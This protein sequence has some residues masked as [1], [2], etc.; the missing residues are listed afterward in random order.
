MSEP[1]KAGDWV[2]VIHWHPCGCRLGYVRQVY[3]IYRNN[4]RL[5]YCIPCNGPRLPVPD[6]DLIRA[7]FTEGASCPASWLRK[8]PPLGELES[9]ETKER[10]TA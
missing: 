6:S 5:R 4:K 2:Q 3:I 1:I 9:E 7:V 8:I 10:I